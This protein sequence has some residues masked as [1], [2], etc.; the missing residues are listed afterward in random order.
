MH[1]PPAAPPRV[2]PRRVF[3][4][5]QQGQL[6]LD[7][8]GGWKDATA[9]Q[10]ACALEPAFVWSATARLAPLVS[11]RGALLGCLP[12]SCLPCPLLPM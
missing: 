12:A 1:A 2:T 10:R 9:V 3:T 5:Q 4:L 7:I 8:K 11:L 6:R